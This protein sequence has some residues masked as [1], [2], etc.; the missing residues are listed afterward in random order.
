MIAIFISTWD[1]S[2]NLDPIKMESDLCL[3]WECTGELQQSSNDFQMGW[4]LNAG[5]EKKK[6]PEK[7]KTLGKNL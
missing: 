6:N 3:P 2:L 5:G 7:Q 1:S 4:E